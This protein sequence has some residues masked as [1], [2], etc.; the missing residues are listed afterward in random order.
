MILHPSIHWPIIA[1]AW[2]VS[3]CSMGTAQESV[4][5]A[6][7][8]QATL[9]AMPAVELATI[10]GF[11]DVRSYAV[12]MAERAA[13][14]AG[15]AGQAAS[16]EAR[17]ETLLRA[18]NLILA[19]Q[20]E[21]ACTSRLLRISDEQVPVVAEEVRAAL[22]RAEDLLA[23]AE[24]AMDKDAPNDEKWKRWHGRVDILRAFAESQR[25]FLA[26]AD[27][28][29]AP[30]DARRAASRLSILLEHE[31]PQVTAAAALWQAVL[32]GGEPD[33]SP[34]LSLLEPALWDL[35]RKRL[36][37][38]Y[39]GRLLRCR[40]LARQGGYATSLALLARIEDRC[41]EWFSDDEE[42][43]NAVRAANLVAWQVLRA[44]FDHLTDPTDEAE[45]I[46]C[47]QRM[48]KLSA[49][50]F[51][52]AG[53]TVLRL[54]PAVPLFTAPPDTD[55]LAPKEPLDED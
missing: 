16:P 47:A 4:Q 15:Q 41:T 21:P 24:Q 44:W 6:E 36:P 39:Y 1:T 10:E 19:H 3:I 32:R 11:A 50:A 43:D 28:S 8:P 45:R 40:L 14:L 23:E 48:E 2:A 34:A 18:A 46:W 9:P 52:E 51:G 55:D 26:P 53:R 33:P 12:A 25:A 37:F 35:P 7:V 27:E 42:R 49:E 5:R 29:E 31:N 22:T 38:A 54:N 17:V 30:R 20:L 13:G